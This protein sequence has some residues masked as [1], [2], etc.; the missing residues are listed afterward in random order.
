MPSSYPSD[1]DDLTT[2]AANATPS[3]DVHPALHNDANAAINAVQETLG[4][5]PQGASADVAARLDGVDTALSGKAASVH[6]HVIG[7][8]TSLQDAL[9]GKADDADVTALAASTTTA[10]AG[11]Q[12]ALDAEAAT[13]AAADLA[14]TQRLSQLLVVR[15][16]RD[17]N[18]DIASPGAS[19]DGTT[20][21]AGDRVFCTSQTTPSEEGLYVWNGAAV[22][23]TRP[24]D[25]STGATIPSGTSVLVIGGASYGGQLHSL[26]A[27]CL[28][29][30]DNPA[31]TSRSVSIAGT[32]TITGSKTLSGTTTIS[33]ALRVP[34][35][36][37]YGAVARTSAVT[38]NDSSQVHNRCDTTAGAFT[39][40]LPA[41]PA[42]GQ[43][44]IVEDGSGTAD[45]NAI[46]I[47]RNGA[48]IGNVASDLVI[49]VERGIA[50]LMY[51]GVGDW[52][53]LSHPSLYRSAS[54]GLTVADTLAVT[55]TLSTNGAASIN[56]GAVLAGFLR[57]TTGT[58]TSNITLTSTNAC[59]N[60]CD[61]TAGAF[62]VTLPA[63][64]ANGQVVVISDGSGTADT[65]AV[66]I[67]RNGKTID[68]AAADLTLNV[69]RGCYVLVYDGVGNWEVW[70]RPEPKCRTTAGAPSH[71]APD[72]TMHLD[73]TN[74]RLY[75]RSGGVWKY[76]A[77]T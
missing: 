60:V 11:L 18:I 47:G 40:T 28:V 53:I 77:L 44:V 65:N 2:D 57:I 22:P 42:S 25:W 49:S 39:I 63:S 71:T 27:D 45:T 66:T 50:V 10:L 21:A 15:V 55:G 1:L 46:T 67:A 19:I 62:T 33:G 32:Q 51:D 23:M 48:T 58:R 37:S 61:S 70:A 38:L 76:T 75:V 12:G 35:A 64:P 36:H 9:D 30:T 14:L 29:G 5:D 31:F 24:V 6:G 43:L 16:L 20:L 72:G 3:V 34:G 54:G 68:D 13:R 56:S 8:V 59:H 7:D 41:T 4:L 74:H 26:T 52:K 17:T 73:T 69:E